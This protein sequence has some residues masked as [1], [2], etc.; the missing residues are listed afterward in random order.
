MNK[1]SITLFGGVNEIGGNKILLQDRDTKIF[2]DF[3]LPFSKQAEYFAGYLCPRG[4]NGAGDYLEFGLL[5]NLKGLYAKDAIKNTKIKYADPEIDAI[6]ISHAHLDH[7]GYLHFIDEKIPVYCGEG[8]KIIIDAI[9]ESS[10]TN[11]GEHEYRT[12]RTGKKIKI[13]SLEI[14]PVHVDH[15]IPAAYGFIIHTSE[16]TIVYSGDMRTHGPLNQMTWEF[17]EKANEA[18]VDLMISEGTR[19]S[20]DKT[21][22]RHSE[23]KV[24]EE[25]NKVV[26]KASKLVIASFYSRD[27][28]RFKTFYEI[29]KKNDRKFVIPI[30][31]AHFVHKLKDDPKLRIPDVMKD[32]NIIFYKKRKKSGEYKERDYYVWERPFID[33]AETFN[34]VRENQ[35]KIIFN[36]DLIRFTELIDVKPSAGGDF[37]HSMSEP[38]SEEDIETRVLHNWLD[39]FGLRFYQIHA[40]GHCPPQ[41]LAKV[42]NIIQPRKLVPIHTEHPALF[43]KLF[44]SYPV[45]LVEE[46]REILL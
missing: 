40:S 33:K 24:K 36:L 34:Y 23:T 45:M 22:E 28:D 27:I 25:S 44:R 35:S 6:I 32:E 29:A 15:S 14:A 26:E 9:E 19:I 5:P 20:P 2:L 43:R 8:T 42:I 46:G 39:H 4:V 38:F 7:I 11:L 31:L 18:D 1:T 41:D 16:G 10:R 30:R 3:G 13:G 17:A 21:S 12:F 37:I